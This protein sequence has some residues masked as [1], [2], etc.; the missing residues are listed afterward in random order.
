MLES[1]GPIYVGATV[2]LS[3]SS[4]EHK[5]DVISDSESNFINLEV[6]GINNQSKLL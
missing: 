3:R 5:E 2:L 6:D 4:K 1:H